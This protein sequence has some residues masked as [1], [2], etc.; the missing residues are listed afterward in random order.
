MNRRQ[1]LVRSGAA[2]LTLGL[3]N[4]PLGWAAAADGAKKRILMYTRSQ[5]FQHDCVRRKGGKL[6]LAEGIITEL[7]G[8]HG[9][10]VVCEKDGRVFLSD[11][12]P[13]FDGFLFETQGNLTAEKSTDGTPP[14]TAEGKKRLLDAVAG[15]KG[16]VGCHCASDTFHS[17]GPAF[18]NQPPDDRDPY[19]RMVGGE[20][21]RH[22]QQQKAWMRVADHDF[23]GLKDLKDFELHEEWYSLKNFA[24]DLH[25][26]L[27]QDTKGMKN[28]D[29]ER[30]NFPATWAH[31]YKKGRVFYSSMG[32]R[33]DVWQ[34]PTFQEVLLG[35][36]AWSLGNVNADV[37]PNI[38][39]VTPEAS[40]LPMKK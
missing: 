33:D 15:G 30:P 16:F 5:G 9:F 1:M 19:I 32:H 25:V 12:F 35:G 18:M 6:S 24:D 38:T 21:I 29:Y 14:M 20:F 40:Q 34:S 4:F 39:K 23:P 22:G 2:A 3:S 17:K 11:D 36:L 8:K 7:G 10:E 37:T 28:F 27:V 31:P 13:K 26:I